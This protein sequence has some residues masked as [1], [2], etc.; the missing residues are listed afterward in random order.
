MP[1]ASQ[2]QPMGFPGRL[3]AIR[4]PTIGKGRKGS[5]AQNGVLLPPVP[6]L[7]G[8]RTGRVAICRTTATRNKT[9]Q[10]A[11]S[12][13]ASH[14]VALILIPLAPCR[15]A[16]FPRSRRHSTV[17]Q[18][19]KR[20]E[21]EM[22]VV[23]AARKERHRRRNLGSTPRQ[24]SKQHQ[25]ANRPQ[26]PV[27]ASRNG[28]VHVRA[29]RLTG[30]A[31][32]CVGGR[33]PGLC[34]LV[35]LLSGLLATP[36]RGGFIGQPAVAPAVAEVDHEPYRH[37]DEEPHP[38][39]GGQETHEEEARDGGEDRHHGV[40]GYLERPR[41]IWPRPPENYDSNGDQHEGGERPDVH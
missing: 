5:M 2:I 39:A 17:L 28:P 13:Q 18:S 27:L 20:Y 35:R 11:A 32:R 6:Q 15:G 26:V 19:P 36:F 3:E 10:R 12:D 38:C 33:G 8:C 29:R 24:R 9:T 14:E 7:L 21:V 41:E 34:A 31:G 1:E 4:A 23:K 37:P 22:P 30:S 25:V 16:W 40:A